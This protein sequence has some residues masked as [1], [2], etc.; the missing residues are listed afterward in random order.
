MENSLRCYLCRKVITADTSYNT[1]KCARE[2]M[3]IVHCK[4]LPS[5]IDF[6][7]IRTLANTCGNSKKH[8]GHF[9]R[10]KDEK[11]VLTFCTCLHDT[12]SSK[13]QLCEESVDLTNKIE[14][15]VERPI[16][17]K[18]SKKKK[19]EKKEKKVT[20]QIS[21]DCDFEGKCKGSDFSKVCHRPITDSKRQ[22]CSFHSR[23]MIRSEELAKQMIESSKSLHP[24]KGSDELISETKHEINCSKMRRDALLSEIEDEISVGRSEVKNNVSEQNHS[25]FNLICTDAPNLGERLFHSKKES[26]DKQL[27]SQNL[28]TPPELLLPPPLL[29]PNEMG[30]IFDKK[31]SIQV[32][33]IN[34]PLKMLLVK[35]GLEEYISLF[36]RNEILSIENLK[37]LSEQDLIQIGIID[38]AHRKLLLI[39]LQKITFVSEELLKCPLS[40]K[41]FV[42]PVIA[43]DGF[44]YSKRALE[45]YILEKFK[46]GEKTQLPVL[47]PIS[48][49]PFESFSMI[50]NNLVESLLL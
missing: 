21:D 38:M 2:H 3:F 37:L 6:A 12:C 39:C 47:S 40:N 17:S 5:F 23:K 41:K 10:I 33:E 35:N 4:C 43:S 44:T 49:L 42:E 31:P 20:F 29:N 24:K 45:S 28:K 15:I 50:P 27:F 30:E 7:K 48:G 11:K 32:Q 26:P 9:K 34:I 36:E 13:L 1:I 8:S 22:M 25:S 16:E 18:S 14:N 46:E 19:K